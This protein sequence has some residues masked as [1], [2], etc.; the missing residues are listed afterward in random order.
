MVGN[1]WP[2][3][4]N[5]DHVLVVRHLHRMNANKEE[6]EKSNET[7][8]GI[9]AMKSTLLILVARKKTTRCRSLFFFR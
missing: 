8:K 1:H 2:K 7:K 9:L 4:H 6:N 3:L 5:H